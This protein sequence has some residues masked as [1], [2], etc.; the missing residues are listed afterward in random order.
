[1]ASFFQKIKVKKDNQFLSQSKTFIKQAEKRDTLPDDFFEQ[2]LACEIQLKKGFSMNT[3][4]K[5]INLYSRAVEYYESINDPRYMRYSK[6]LQVLLLQ[7]QI[8]K[9]INLQT[10]K[11]KIKVHKQERKKELLDEFKNVDK[12]FVN[13]TDAK[14][15]INKTNKEEKAKNFDEAK[16]KDLDTQTSS[17]KKRLAEKKKKWI[18]N[19][20][21]IGQS[22]NLQSK[23]LVIFSNSKKHLNKSFDAIGQDD[24]IFSND[25]SIEPISMFNIGESTFNINDGINN[26]LDFYFNDFDNIFNEK[27]TKGFINKIIEINKEKM[28]EKVNTAKIFAEKI[29]NK[30]FQLTFDSNTEQ[31]ERDKIS[32]EIFE[33]G[34]EQNKKY[35]EI[36][37]KYEQKIQ[38]AKEE[39]KNQSI[40]TMEWIKN[41]KEKYISDI[42]SVIYNF[43]G[44]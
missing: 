2:I 44:N 18:M 4:R 7:P 21:D 41:L 34:E 9:Q 11:G 32:K 29:K 22:S 26:N 25:L 10:K 23:N 28:E 5:L 13:N 39:L 31:E 38:E 19:T 43:I 3:L 42:D 37:K 8:V 12:K 1:M 33:L 14:D 27:I 35:D 40:Q 30:E 6:S 20:S 36:E 15:I 16:N 24:S 17:F